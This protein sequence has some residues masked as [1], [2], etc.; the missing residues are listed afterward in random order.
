MKLF[1]ARMAGGVVAFCLS[2]A[3]LAQSSPS[4]APDTSPPP[5]EP[6]PS[7]S[8]G[9]VI[10]SRS[11]DE[12]GQTTTTNGPAATN[13]VA[14]ASEPIATDDERSALAF[15]SYNMDVRLRPFEQHIEVRAQI[16]VRNTG[17]TPLVHIP[18]QL[19][20]SLTWDRIRLNGHDVPFQVATLNSDADHTGQLR[21]AAITPA[22]PLPP[23]VTAQVDVTYS[24]KIAQNAQRLLAVG[25]P[26]DVAAHSDWDQITSDFTG[27][28][29]FG[30]VLW[31]PTAS[32]PVILGDGARLFD[33]MDQHKLHLSGTQFALHL[34]VEFPTGQA[35]TIAL[36][37]GQSAVLKTTAGDEQIN[38]VATAD[39]PS[40]TL[41]F[42]E[43]SLFVAI[44]KSDPATNLTLWT[45]PEDESNA[46]PWSTAATAVTPFLQ[47]WLGQTPRSQLAIL[48]L[49]DPQDAPF[50]TGTL[51]A[52]PIHPAT[53]SVLET[54]LAHSLTHAWI[55]S[56]YAW[57]NE[58]VATFMGTLWLQNTAGR[59]KALESLEAD[60]SALAL[61][62]PASPGTSAGEPLQQAGSPIYYRTKAAYIFW[63]L[64]DL[65]GDTALNAALRSLNPSTD[66]AAFEKLLQQPSQRDLHWFFADW[67]DADKGLPDLAIAKVVPLA[68]Q[69]G[70]T[71]V[72]ITIANNGYAAAEVPVTVFTRDTAVT[73]RVLV[74]ARGSITPRILILGTPTKVQV[75]DGTVPEVQASEHVTTLGPQE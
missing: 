51:L 59:A 62:E 72:G 37:N 18:L 22:V 63:M 30:N 74:P 60:R 26:D 47:S 32:V 15:T 39:L 20:S 19:S 29:G 6:P 10:Y 42:D 48:D 69:A 67:I 24:G 50:E 46:I 70:N 52:T 28:R 16:V 53:D 49:P 25:A 40:S 57:L 27:L 35:P 41:G 8:H 23:G 44:R 36:I 9:T 34:T 2:L 31:Y 17:K 38:G 68:A 55:Q 21:E 4:Q 5:A 12:N 75:N 3:L 11:T 71:L 65:A 73:Q 45:R 61:A 33:E 14:A 56:P 66:S 54:V 7:P 64:R 58:G 13:S 43:P 1:L